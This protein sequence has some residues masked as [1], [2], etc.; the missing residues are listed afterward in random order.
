MKRSMKRRDCGVDSG[1]PDSR[2]TGEILS[3]LQLGAHDLLEGECCLEV[4]I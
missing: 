3:E 1:I 2:P 4:V